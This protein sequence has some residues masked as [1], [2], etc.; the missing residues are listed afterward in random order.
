MKLNEYQRA[1]FQIQI[2]FFFSVVF[3]RN[4]WDICNKISFEPN[5]T[6]GMKRTWYDLGRFWPPFKGL[7]SIRGV[8]GPMSK[9]SFTLSNYSFVIWDKNYRR[10]FVI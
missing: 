10:Y 4:Y 7:G 5:G 1:R 3:F 8:F 9:I 6:M 2:L